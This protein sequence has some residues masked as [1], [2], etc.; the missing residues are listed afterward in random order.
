MPD[1]L[2]RGYGEHSGCLA[3]MTHFPHRR[4]ELFCSLLISRRSPDFRL[5]QPRQL[6]SHGQLECRFQATLERPIV[7]VALWV[8]TATRQPLL[9]IHTVQAQRTGTLVDAHHDHAYTA[10]RTH[11]ELDLNSMLRRNVTVAM[12]T[13]GARL[14]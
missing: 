8:E 5:G 10:S 11:S 13:G 9:S 4:D 3:R 12:P 6:W 14:E 1:L 7:Y 2:S